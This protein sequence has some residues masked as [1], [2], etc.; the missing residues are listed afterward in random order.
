MYLHTHA[1]IHTTYTH[2]CSIMNQPIDSGTGKGALYSGS[3]D[4]LVKTAS[5]E[6]MLAIYK[7]FFAQWL[8]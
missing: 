2:T 1:H 5:T 6:G 3:L 8:R 4:C 7:G